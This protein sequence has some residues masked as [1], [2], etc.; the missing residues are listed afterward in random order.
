MIDS[1]VRA[2]KSEGMESNREGIRCPHCGTWNT[3]EECGTYKFLNPSCKKCGEC[4]ESEHYEDVKRGPILEAAYRISQTQGIE[5]VDLQKFK[6]NGDEWVVVDEPPVK[7][8]FP[9]E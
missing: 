4:T 3:H 9:T 1:F 6:Y 7:V 5:S 2:D 8:V